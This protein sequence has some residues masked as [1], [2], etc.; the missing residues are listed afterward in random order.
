MSVEAEYEEIS[1]L[2]EI[3]ELLNEGTDTNDILSGVLKKLLHV[4]GLQT[5]WIFLIDENGTHHL[6]AD[7]ALPPALT[8][9]TKQ[10]MC[11]GNCWCVNKYNNHQLKKATNIMECKRIEEAMEENAGE[12]CGLTHHATVPLGAGQERFGLLNVGSPYKT[13]FEKNELALL[14]AVAYQIGTAL[15]RIKLTQRE[16]ETALIAER[17]RLARDLHDSVNQLLFSL[18]LTARAGVEMT[19]VAEVKQTFNYIQDLAQE[20]LGEMRALIWQLRPQGLENGLI[21]ALRSYAEML[22]LAIET[23]VM[24]AASIPGK[25]EEALWRIG[26]EALANCKKHSQSTVVKLFFHT[27]KDGVA[28]TVQDNGC[29]FHFEEELEI[30]SLGLKNMKSPTEALKGKFQL[31]SKP[32]S[33]TE[34]QIY[35]PF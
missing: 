27:A 15:K 10:R 25:V 32:G 8:N 24:G 26:Q 9:N 23:N 17:N 29:G 34:I 2:K 3:A 21:S 1:I 31:N 20:A 16:Q 35:I 7:E 30:P 14:E 11:L 19:S 28:M 13:H 6:A 5:G 22:G 33:G 12:T 18:S 4:T